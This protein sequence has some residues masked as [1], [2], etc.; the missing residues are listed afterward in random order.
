MV[1]L[2]EGY[3]EGKQLDIAAQND[4]SSSHYHCAYCTT[5]T[6]TSL[7]HMIRAQLPAPHV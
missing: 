2:E 7:I 6:I 5:A 3:E 1:I 4:S